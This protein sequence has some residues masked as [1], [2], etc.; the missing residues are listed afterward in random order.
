MHKKI[1]SYLSCKPARQCSSQ[2]AT[3]SQAMLVLAAVQQQSCDLLTNL[4][5][6]LAVRQVEHNCAVRFGH[7]I[8]SPLCSY[9]RMPTARSS[10]RSTSFS[11]PSASVYLHV[12]R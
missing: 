2:I 3:T 6:H 4:I 9:S 8:L 10:R 7:V 12:C 5:L 1:C 11:L